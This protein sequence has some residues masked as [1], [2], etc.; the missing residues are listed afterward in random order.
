M[1]YEQEINELKEQFGIMD[2]EKLIEKIKLIINNPLVELSVKSNGLCLIG[3]II[4]YLSPY[5]EDDNGYSYFKKALE[6]DET[7][8]DAILGI[9]FIFNTYPYPFNTIVTEVEYLSYIQRLI[10]EFDY[11][12]ERQRLNMLQSVKGYSSY[13][14]K[15][16]EKYG[17]P[18]KIQGNNSF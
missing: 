17:Y 13:R 4:C 16:I 18:M 11:M 14:A 5:L 8:Y 6:F 12:E 1:T 3:S 10:E 9:C 7:N 15:V 2:S